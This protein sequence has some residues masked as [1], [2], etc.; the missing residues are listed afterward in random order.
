MMR[1]KRI[2]AALMVAVMT[3]TLLGFG[4]S[5]NAEDTSSGQIVY[6]L[7]NPNSG[8][9][10]FT[11][12]STDKDYLYSIGWNYEGIGWIAPSS[13]NP[14]YRLYNPYSGE[15]LYTKDLSDKNWL[16]DAGWNDEGTAFYTN[17][18]KGRCETGVYRLYNPYSGGSAGAHMFTTDSKQKDEL[19]SLG[20]NY[21]KIGFY[22]AHST[23]YHVGKYIDAL[24]MRG[25]QVYCNDCGK[26][27]F[28]GWDHSGSDFDSLEE[29]MA[30]HL[31]D[32][33]GGTYDIDYVDPA[34][35]TPFVAPETQDEYIKAALEYSAYVLPRIAASE[36]L[37][38]HFTIDY[39]GSDYS[40]RP[41]QYIIEPGYAVCSVCGEM[42][43]E[44]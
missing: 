17:D 5:A 20:W 40:I 25:S 26:M 11:V 7:Y 18:G 27:I 2:I 1:R 8:E 35:W 31:N 21:E 6:R 38:S 15:H 34:R 33:H 4:V 19:V 44:K 12:K 29:L 43:Y 16:I 30:R 10:L 39:E 37:K 24:E 23:T 32:E 13:G 36:E 28:D 3:I 22:A 42:F 9:H 41:K 14:V